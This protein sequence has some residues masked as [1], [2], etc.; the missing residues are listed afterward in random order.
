[1]RFLLGPSG[2]GK[3][4]RCLAEVRAALIASPEGPPLL[5]LAPKQATFQLERQLLSD[6]E[7]PGYTRLQ[8]LSFERLAEF[9]LTEFSAARPRL[10]SEDGRLM[11]LRA[12]LARQRTNLRV[13]HATARLRGFAHEL[14][15][16]IRELL[17]AQIS[18]GQLHDL[19]KKVG[20]ANRL[21][22][23]LRDL[24]TLL[25]AYLAWLD[26]HHLQDQ[27]RLLMFAADLLRQAHRP[28]EVGGQL[29]FP[30]TW[31]TPEV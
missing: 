3:T 23:K 18:A 5:F 26:Q 25:E 11:V 17:R 6:P 24:G 7:V 15:M 22:A 4:F 19:A 27:D 13:F 2:T 9:V 16:V 29:L 28:V 21:D 14:S 31:Q 30:Q 8:I 20:P 1:M 12:I 10:L